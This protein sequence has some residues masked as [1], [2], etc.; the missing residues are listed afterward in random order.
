MTKSKQNM[1]KN[2]NKTIKKRYR[3]KLKNKR[4]K[5]K[6]RQTKRKQTTK[7]LLK[8]GLSSNQFTF[9]NI[10]DHKRKYKYLKIKYPDENT[11]MKSWVKITNK[12]NRKLSFQFFR[13]V[14]EEPTA[15]KKDD[16]IH[17]GQI[18]DIDTDDPYV[19]KDNEG[20]TVLDLSKFEATIE[21]N[22]AIRRTINKC[23]KPGKQ[24]RV[25]ITL[26]D[27]IE[28]HENEKYFK[29]KQPLGE[30]EIEDEGMDSWVKIIKEENNKNQF[31]IQYLYTYD[32]ENH[33]IY[34]PDHL[35][36]CSIESHNYKAKCDEE[37][38]N[39][40]PYSIFD[41]LSI[42][43]EADENTK[44]FIDRDIVLFASE[45]NGYNYNDNN[46][47]NDNNPY[48]QYNQYNQYNHNNQYN[49]Y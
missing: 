40:S 2:N 24:K 27:I 47:N 36:K 17:D 19:C 8:G 15:I 35:T 34:H 3:R 20:N 38:E 49:D 22:R 23:N 14:D 10:L 46:Y 7:K 29:I 21:E 44:T 6:R 18:Y 9:Q 16:S 13:E 42:L 25:K 39:I 1:K 45:N 11:H 26:G 28:D 31:T 12:R 33:A 30:G 41:T 4:K 37:G 5:T 43:K 48:N 32:D